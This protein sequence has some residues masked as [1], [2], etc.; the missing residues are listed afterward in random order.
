MSCSLNR[1][2]DRRE[3]ALAPT[4]ARVR[5][6][7]EYIIIYVQFGSGGEGGERGRRKKWLCELS[8]M[9]MSERTGCAHFRRPSA[10]ESIGKRSDSKL[11]SFSSRLQ[12][13]IHHVIHHG[14]NN[15]Y[16]LTSC[17]IER[18][19]E[20]EITQQTS[21][22]RRRILHPSIIIHP[23]SLPMPDTSPKANTQP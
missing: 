2:E 3:E 16:S 17:R 4:K 21:S 7:I 19:K 23:F 11:P 18:V 20:N 15:S 13:S 5:A 9:G 1:R 14:T 22:V 6:K 8:D 10:E 12:Q